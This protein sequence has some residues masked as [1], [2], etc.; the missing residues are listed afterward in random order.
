MGD[1]QVVKRG[2]RLTL[3]EPILGSSPKNKDVYRSFIAAKAAEAA[4]TMAP[5]LVVETE[6]ESVQEVE[7]RGWTGFL[8][9][10]DGIYL[11][12]YVIRG[13]LKSAARVLS[14]KISGKRKGEVALGASV[15]DN[16]VFVWPRKIR[17]VR[18]GA[19]IRGPEDVLERPLRAM[20]AQGPR[21]T[22]MRS[23]LV[24]EDATIDVTIGT[25]NGRV[26]ADLIEQLLDYGQLQGLGQ[27]RNGS[28][29]RF[30]WERIE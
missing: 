6:V 14:L 9:D 19:P 17:L 25:L 26:P 2:Y 28:Y 27:W 22:V 5:A 21:V 18:D 4:V 12:D 24:R 7:E 13:Y 15:I 30:T 23:D 29:G 11:L 20:T 10:A 1:L 3:T 16:F 8:E